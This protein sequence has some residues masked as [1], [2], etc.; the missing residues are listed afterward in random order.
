MTKKIIDTDNC[1]HKW[2]TIKEIKGKYRS[3]ISACPVIVYHQQCKNCGKLTDFV[4]RMPDEIIYINN[5]AAKE[6]LTK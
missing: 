4:A 1:K 6:E 5:L 2:Q 3:F